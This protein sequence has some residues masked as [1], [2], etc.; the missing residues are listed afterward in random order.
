MTGEGDMMQ[1]AKKLC[2]ACSYTIIYKAD[3]GVTVVLDQHDSV[4]SFKLMRDE[5]NDLKHC[6]VCLQCNILVENSGYLGRP[7]MTHEAQ[8][9]IILDKITKLRPSA[10][11]DAIYRLTHVVEAP[12]GPP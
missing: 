11:P 5:V 8:P 9:N 10:L 4:S 2:V 1:T 3:I 7:C 6:T 12:Q